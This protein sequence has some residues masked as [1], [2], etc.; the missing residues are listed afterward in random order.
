MG[1]LSSIIMKSKYFISAI[2]IE[3]LMLFTEYK[4]FSWQN[5]VITTTLTALVWWGL[6]LIENKNGQKSR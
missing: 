4:P 6:S 1:F 5:L 3:V 2:F